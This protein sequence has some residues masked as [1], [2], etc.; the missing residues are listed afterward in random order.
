MMDG[1][2]VVRALVADDEEFSRQTLRALLGRETGIEIVGE[3]AS[4]LDARQRIGELQPELVFLDI[5]M[6]AGRA[7]D[8][9]RSLAEPRPYLVAMTA[10]PQLALR[11]F[12][13]EADDY[14]MKPLQ[15]Q[16]IE[17]GVTRAMKRI[18]ERRIAGF[19][20]QIAGAAISIQRDR[21]VGSFA[22][23]SPYPDQMTIRVRRR[24]FS[25]DVNDITWIQG[26]S[27]YSRVHAR[28]GEFLLSRTLASLECELDPSRFFRIHRSAI[29]NAAYIQEVRSRGDGC[30][31][32]YLQGGQG[33]PMGRARREILEKLLSSV[34]RQ[35]GPACEF[36]EAG[37]SPGAA[38]TA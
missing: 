16:R 9:W 7:I 13:I 32:V 23:S 27:Q 24:L 10:H 26:A 21:A 34:G 1:R 18:A 36:M 31:N 20:M 25:L 22:P 28:T 14:F 37:A 30:Y 6:Q 12:E 17:A 38:R 35:Y 33:L 29:V 5:G 3:S 8:M 11:A 19:A 15:R 2:S 4:A